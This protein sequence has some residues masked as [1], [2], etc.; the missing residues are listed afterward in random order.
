MQ[1]FRGFVICAGFSQRK[2][3]TCAI[4]QRK[5]SVKVDGKEREMVAYLTAGDT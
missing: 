5:V 4:V 2:D 1:V 3:V